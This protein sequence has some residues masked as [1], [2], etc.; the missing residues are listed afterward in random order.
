MDVY[1][2]VSF[3]VDDPGKAIMYAA[4]ISGASAWVCTLLAAPKDSSGK[5]YKTLYCV[6]NWIGA[7]KGKAKNADEIPRLR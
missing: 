5:A 6:L 4:S 3:F 1:T 2:I 7:N